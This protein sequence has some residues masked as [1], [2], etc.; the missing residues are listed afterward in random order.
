MALNYINNREIKFGNSKPLNGVYTPGFPTREYG[1]LDSMGIYLNSGVPVSYGVE[2]GRYMAL[3]DLRA[4]GFKDG[5][6]YSFNQFFAAQMML[7]FKTHEKFIAYD[8]GHKIIGSGRVLQKAYLA[9]IDE[10]TIDYFKI[11]I[12]EDKVRT[13]CIRMTSAEIP[14]SYIDLTNSFDEDG[15]NLTQTD[16]Q[17]FLTYYRFYPLTLRNFSKRNTPGDEDLGTGNYLTY[18]PKCLKELSE[19]ILLKFDAFI[20]RGV[21]TALGDLAFV[22]AGDVEYILNYSSMSRENAAVIEAAANIA[23]GEPNSLV[24]Q[25]SPGV[26]RF[27]NANQGVLYVAQT[28]DKPAFGT[29][30]VSAGGTGLSSLNNGELL[31][32]SEG[33]IIQISR[34]P[35]DGQEYALYQDSKGNPSWKIFHVSVDNISPGTDSSSGTKTEIIKT[36]KVGDESLIEVPGFA[37]PEETT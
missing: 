23:G 11:K 33:G 32:G 3:S 7:G 13:F 1:P 28:G 5:T 18:D 31:C 36:D 14:T 17:A 25:E 8:M 4:A 20:G 6:S 29:L 22:Y 10:K 9:E 15:L 21:L 34:A 24:Y 27:I 37:T 12:Y 30:P 26:T 2:N 35:D 16:R 19:D